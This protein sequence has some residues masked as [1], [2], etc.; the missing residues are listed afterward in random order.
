MTPLESTIIAGK[1]NLLANPTANTID[2]SAQLKPAKGDKFALI[3]DT[4]VGEY[5]YSGTDWWLRKADGTLEKNN[6][7]LPRVGA[8]SGFWYYSKGAEDVTI[9]W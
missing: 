3:G 8:N 6:I 4:Y 9:K 1:T 2:I 5:V 7:T